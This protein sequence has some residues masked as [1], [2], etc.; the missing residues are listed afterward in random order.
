MNP[1][2]RTYIAQPKQQRQFQDPSLLLA[3]AL[4]QQHYQ[5]YTTVDS[6]SKNNKF[7]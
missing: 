7:L 1:S 6:V 5:P 3:A 4:L 2:R